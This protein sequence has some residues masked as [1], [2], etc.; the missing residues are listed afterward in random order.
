MTGVLQGFGVIGVVIAIGYLLAARGVLDAVAQQALAKVVFYVATPAQLYVILVKADL[1]AGLGRSF[2]IAVGSV[3]GTATLYIL[4]SRAV[5]RH[6]VG[7]TTIGALASS[8]VNAGNLGIPI[9]VYVLGNGSAIAPLLI[10]QMLF[11]AP[12]AFAILDGRRGAAGAQSPPSMRARIGATFTNP[13]TLGA[14]LGVLVAASG[15][16]PPGMLAQSVEMVAGLAVPGALIVYGISLKVDP[17]SFADGPRLHVTL[18]ALFKLVVQP[19]LAVL[20]AAYGFG[21]TGHDLLAAAVC[22]ALPTAQ[23]IYVYAMRYNAAVT[24][25]RDAI[26]ATTVLCVPTLMVIALVF[27]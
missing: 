9:A 27:A 11:M 17:V 23:N 3:I 8:Y 15:F 5:F 25:A 26:F 1:G 20:I 10:L 2:A 21:L 16:Q 14:L 22:G 24:L 13:V 12:L 19:A 18:I 6:D 7:T 4:I